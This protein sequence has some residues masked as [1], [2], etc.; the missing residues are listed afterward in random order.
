M[1]AKQV[2]IAMKAHTPVMCGGILYPRIMRYIMWID[3]RD[4]IHLAAEMLD[5]NGSTRV[6]AP[7]EQITPCENGG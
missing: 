4:E 6:T 3:D 2:P 1:E 7:I 5:K